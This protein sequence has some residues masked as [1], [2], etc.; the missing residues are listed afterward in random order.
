[1]ELEHRRSKTASK[2]VTL[3]LEKEINKAIADKEQYTAELARVEALIGTDWNPLLIIKAKREIKEQDEVIE[4]A[5]LLLK[6]VEATV[7]EYLG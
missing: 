4:N 2:E 5:E 6:E 3:D 1:M 7:E